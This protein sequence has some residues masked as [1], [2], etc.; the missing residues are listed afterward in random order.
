VLILVVATVGCGGDVASNVETSPDLD[1]ERR[2][3]ARGSPVTLEKL[4][5]TARANGIRLD[6]H[7]RGCERAAA[8]PHYPDATNAG[9]SGLEPDPGV[10]RR[11]GHV[12]CDVAEARNAKNR[13]VE[14]VK[15]PTDRETQVGVLNVGC[16]VY[17]SDAAS[18]R[19]QVARLM[20]ALEALTRA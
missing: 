6:V 16:A 9:P 7:R 5:K 20:R 4:I 3:G 12:I 18:E 8:D 17:P 14:V 1:L 11:E 15:Y 19:R 13:S 10:F 2:C